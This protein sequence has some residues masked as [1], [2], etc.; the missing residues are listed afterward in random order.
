MFDPHQS[1]LPNNRPGL[2][3]RY[4]SAQVKQFTGTLTNMTVP[5][6]NCYPLQHTCESDGYQGTLFRLPLRQQQQAD[7]SQIS[8][9]VQSD[10][11]MRESLAKFA[12]AAPEM[13]LFLKHV[14]EIK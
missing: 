5:Q 1:V 6:V 8:S 12:R 14:E 7:T 4:T 13:M 2:R 9:C 3:C 10:S 11:E